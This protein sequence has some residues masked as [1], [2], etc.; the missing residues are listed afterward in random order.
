MLVEPFFFFFCGIWTYVLDRWALACCK[1]QAQVPDFHFKSAGT[2]WEDRS[3]FPGH[4]T[5]REK[6]HHNI[7]D[8]L[9]YWRVG[10]I[11][12]DLTIVLFHNIARHL[13]FGQK[14][15]F[16]PPA[17]DYITHFSQCSS[18]ITRHLHSWL[19]EGKKNTI[20]QVLP[21][22]FVALRWCS[23]SKTIL[24]FLTI[25]HTLDIGIFRHVYMVA[26]AWFTKV[27][28]NLPQVDEWLKEF[29]PCHIIF[30]PRR[31]RKPG[32]ATYLF[33]NTLGNLVRFDF[34]IK[35]NSWGANNYDTVTLKY[36][37]FYFRRINS[38]HV[39]FI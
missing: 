6:Q 21:N 1:I 15:L 36:R 28:S 19:Y 24:N 3:G 37:G 30:I 10:I 39:R 26:V 16:F 14:A 9:P 8:I 27:F 32:M 29:D 33:L 34:G 23:Y 5:P 7:R 2:P 13:F 18:S 20:L 22:I 12:F 31:N 38:S 4:H 25:A 11:W 17:K 35:K